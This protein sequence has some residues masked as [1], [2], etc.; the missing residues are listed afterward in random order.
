MR[1]DDNA[2]AL[3]RDD[4]DGD[5]VERRD[6]DAPGVEP[7]GDAE[8]AVD[9]DWLEADLG[10]CDAPIAERLGDADLDDLILDD[11]DDA[12]E[13]DEWEM[14]LFQEMG[15]DLDAPDEAGVGFELGGG[16]EDDGALDDEV[17]A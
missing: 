2:A 3:G 10:E 12:D 7:V 4:D 8:F 11:D 17:A 5:D 13:D 16:F 9:E 6:A 1:T 14:A 15:I